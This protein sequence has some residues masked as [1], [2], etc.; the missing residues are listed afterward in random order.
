M[1]KDTKLIP[2]IATALLCF[3]MIGCGKAPEKPAI[4]AASPVPPIEVTTEWLMPSGNAQLQGTAKGDFSKQPEK[5]WHAQLNGDI[6][7]TPV[8]AK[9]RAFV[10]TRDGKLYCLDFETGEIIWQF[11]ETFS[12]EASPVFHKDHIYIGDM[13]GNFYCFNAADGSIIWQ[14]D[15]FSKITGSA[16]F[17]HFPDKSLVIYGSYDSTLFA[18]DISSGDLVWTYTTGSYINGSPAITESGRTVLGSCD[19]NAHVI[20]TQTG[21]SLALIN[22]EVYVPSSI[23]VYEDSAYVGNHEG[24]FFGIDLAKEERMWEFREAR[25]SYMASSAVT[26]ST[27]FAP[28]QDGFL[29][30]LNRL[31]GELKWSLRMGTSLDGSPVVVGDTVVVASYGGVLYGVNTETGEERWQYDLGGRVSGSPAVAD[32]KLLIGDENGRLHLLKFTLPE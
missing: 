15:G 17:R 18:R 31:T 30:A 2:F 21:N 14:V 19:A 13:D 27:V 6:T 7:T 23:P 16:N 26:E 29:Y 10:S 8:I 32:N 12:F 20:D 11:S 28:N 24:S 3:G 1:R 9:S 25:D 5:G 4:S 22:A